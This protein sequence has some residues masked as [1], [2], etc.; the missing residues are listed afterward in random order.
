[1][2]PAGPRPAVSTQAIARRADVPVATL[3][4][5]FPNREAILEELLLEYLDRRDAEAAAVLS[6]IRADT[7]AEAVHHFFEFHRRQYRTH[8]GS[9]RLLRTTGKWPNPR[10]PAAPRAACGTHP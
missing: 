6:R 4:Q 10:P 7:L 2:T 3:Y 9:S 1:M 5:F 8:P